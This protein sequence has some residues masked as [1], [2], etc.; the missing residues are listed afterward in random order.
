MDDIPP[1]FKQG[2]SARARAGFFVLLALLMITVDVRLHVLDKVRMGVGA[3]LYPIQ[4]LALIPRDALYSVGKY[5]E[6]V[7]TLQEENTQLRKQ[8]ILNAQTLQREQQISAENTQLRNLLQM[9]VH[10]PLESVMG[11]VL[12][13]ARDPFTQK[14][15]LN[16]GSQHK[17]TA[18]QPVIDDIGVIGQVTRVF[19]FTS[20]VTL[21]TD[22]DQAIPV[23]VLRNGLR[24][25]A[26]GN[27]QTGELELRF[28]ASSVDIQKGD[29]LVTSGIDSLYP[30]GLA[31]ATV[32]F[33]ETNSTSAFARILCKPI[34]GI[35]RNKFFLILLKD[36]SEAAGAQDGSALNTELN[37]G[38]TSP[39]VK[40][41]GTK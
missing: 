22:Q 10:M 30:P 7:S 3:V 27:G 2:A 5:F 38:E 9:K 31:V 29:I 6:S 32:D 24:S 20:E 25:V 17:V 1:L 37:Q 26:Y 13:D 4:T 15:V 34:A 19:P 23:Q 35:G 21:L 18:G 28:M 39:V 11:E 16:Q 40:Q 14:I 36:E 41:K 12:Y 33:V 8:Q